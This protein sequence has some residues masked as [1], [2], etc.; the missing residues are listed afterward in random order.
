MRH[1]RFRFTLRGWMV[2]VAMSGIV[3]ALDKVAYDFL[4]SL[5]HGE[6]SKSSWAGVRLACGILTVNAFPILL[7][8]LG[9][10]ARYD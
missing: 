4:M 1:R 7:V 2:A 8:W 10:L 3:L 5:H 6:Q 9:R